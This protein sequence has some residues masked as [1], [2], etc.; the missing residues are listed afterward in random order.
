MA[1]QRDAILE[2]AAR[3]GFD[4]VRV[5][6]SVRRREATSRSDVDLLVHA[7]HGVSAFSRAGLVDD[8]QSLLGRRVDVVEDRGIHWLIRPQVMFEA[9]DL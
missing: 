3:R 5:F 8:L 1:P 2:V 7:R 6:G 4:H 9:V